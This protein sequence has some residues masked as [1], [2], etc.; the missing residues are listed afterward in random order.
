MPVKIDLTKEL[1]DTE[2]KP[3][4]DSQTKVPMILRNVLVNGLLADIDQS[5]QPVRGDAKIKRYDLY[6]KIKLAENP[7]AVEITPEESTLLR[8]AVGVF[9]TLI[10]G[11]ARAFLDPKH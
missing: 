5:G 7:L 8:E 3:L 1:V 9:S 2:D 11:Q 4:I 6:I 10:A